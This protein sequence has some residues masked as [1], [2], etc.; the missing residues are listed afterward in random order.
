MLLHSTLDIR[1]FLSSNVVS[2]SRSKTSLERHLPNSELLNPLSHIL[3]LGVVE[4]NGCK[5]KL[6]QLARKSSPKNLVFGPTVVSAFHVSTLCTLTHC[7][8]FA[9]CGTLGASEESSA[10]IPGSFVT[11]ALVFRLQK[12]RDCCSCISPAERRH[13]DS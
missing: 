10:H 4:P 3:K 2:N 1:K 5:Y 13:A 11:A 12:D 8:Y 9:C 7:I 6:L